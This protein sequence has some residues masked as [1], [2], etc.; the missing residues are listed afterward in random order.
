MSVRIS[1]APTCAVY[2]SVTGLPLPIPLFT[3]ADE[4]A[5]FLDYLDRSGYGDPRTLATSDIQDEYRAWLHWH[6]LR[7]KWPLMQESAGG[8]NDV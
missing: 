5:G 3:D 7:Q 1:E 4:A 2:D 8:P 6:T